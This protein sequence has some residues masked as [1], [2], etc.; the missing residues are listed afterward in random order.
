MM[1]NAKSEYYLSMINTNFSKFWKLIKSS[2]GSMLGPAA[3][4]LLKVNNEEIKD[5]HNIA[6]TF[7]MHFTNISS[8][9]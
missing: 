3:P 2:T 5:K 8:I 4:A 7:N 9:T 6:E 1:K